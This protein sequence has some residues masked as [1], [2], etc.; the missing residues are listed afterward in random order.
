MRQRT[1]N[2]LVLDAVPP[3]ATTLIFPVVAPAGTMAVI[4]V[5]ETVWKTAGVPLKYTNVTP[6]KFVPLIVTAAPT[7]PFDGEKLVIV[8]AFTTDVTL[9][10]PLHEPEPPPPGFVTVTFR[11]PAGAEAEIVTLAVR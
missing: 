10:Q 5:A 4:R 11:A 1:L 7:R 8:G 2:E 9:K 6:V 3:A